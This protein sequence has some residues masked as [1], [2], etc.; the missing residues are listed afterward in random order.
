MARVFLLLTLASRAG[1]RRSMASVDLPEPETPEMQVMRPWGIS[2]A[3]LSRVRRRAPLARIQH[4]ASVAGFS[5][6]MR[7]RPDRKAAVRLTGFV[8]IAD[9]GPEATTSPPSSPAPGPMSTMWSAASI[10]SGSCSTVTTVLPR[11]R[12][13]LRVPISWSVSFW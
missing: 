13:R 10:S 12:S 2:K 4:F 1:T 7:L 5:R 6:P 9:S 3:T 11:S 8:K